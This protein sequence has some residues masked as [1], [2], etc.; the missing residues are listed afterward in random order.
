[1]SLPVR[2]ESAESVLDVVGVG[3]GPS[4]LALAIAI[5][6]HNRQCAQPKRV[7]AAFFEKQDCFGWHT[8]MLIDDSTMQVSFMKDLVTVRNPV[9][10]LSFVNYLHSQNRLIDFINHKTLFPLRVEFHDYLEWAARRMAHFVQYSS[11][12]VDVRP[13]TDDNRV[14]GFDVTV[15]RGLSNGRRALYRTRNVVLAAG[16]EPH[17]PAGVELNDRVWHNSQLL[18][19]VEQLNSRSPSAQRLMVV[20][21]GQS[22]AETVE[23]L[24]RC[25]AEAQV[26][27]VFGR[28]GY[29]PSDDSPFANRI[30]D[31]EA[32]DTYFHAPPNI[33]QALFG[34]HRNTNYSVV[35]P[36][37]IEELY[38]RFYRE[39]VQGH[40]RLQIMNASRVIETT[41]TP[42]AVWATVHNMATGQKVQLECD[43]VVYATGYKPVDPIKL[44]GRAG[45]L[46][47]VDPQGLV[48]T[49]RDYR[50]ATSPEIEGGVY[51]QGATD[52]THG[53]ASTLLSNAAV[54][55]GEILESI[56]SRS[57]EDDS[58]AHP[59]GAVASNATSD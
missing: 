1:M 58:Q 41:S 39:K 50:I 26:C 53:I 47:L 36:E 27:A 49:K 10:D 20:G 22:A 52:H 4:N 25:F 15:A 34:Y 51:L 24:H 40:P 57:P 13:L 6:E 19:R 30:F 31:P 7:R 14:T 45:E 38:R 55:A 28:Y 48:Q 23:Y 16:I 59:V 21:A 17:V 44:L 18:S 46:C 33:K 56:L 43:A 54:R 35:D 8:G 32:V 42:Q 11:K 12:V 29:S 9:S 5:H 37:L 2:T 3:F